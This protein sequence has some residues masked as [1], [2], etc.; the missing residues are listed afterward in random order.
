MFSLASQELFAFNLYNIRVA[1]LQILSEGD[2]I[3]WV[4]Q[5]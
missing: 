2:H 3:K 1:L 5:F 4:T